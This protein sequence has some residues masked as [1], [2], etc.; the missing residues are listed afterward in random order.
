MLLLGIIAVSLFAVYCWPSLQ[1]VALV[2]LCVFLLLKLVSHFMV[3]PPWMAQSSGELTT[4]ITGRAKIW[5]DGKITNPNQ[6]YGLVYTDLRITCPTDKY[7]LS[8]WYVRHADNKQQQDDISISSSSSSSSS[9]KQ[10]VQKQKVAGKTCVVLVHG[11]GRDKRAF[12]RHMPVFQK[13]GYSTLAFD[14]REHGLSHKEG[15]G[16]GWTVREAQDCAV[17]SKYVRDTLGYENVVLCGTSQGA[18][19]SIV[20]AATLDKSVDAVIAENP[21]LSRDLLVEEILGLYLGSVWK[22]GVLLHLKKMMSK[23]GVMLVNS[24]LQV[25]AI[26]HPNAIDVIAKLAPRPVLL[27]HGTKDSLIGHHH[28]EL[29]HAAAGEPKALW[30]L[31]GAQHTALWDHDSETWEKTVLEFL[32]KH[33]L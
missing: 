13:A 5:Y 14:C 18:A 9:V 15:K 23:I 30:I 11:G 25:D 4:K 20:A 10:R 17:V 3:N 21:F 26:K 22:L 28:S 2:L 1:A 29:L 19:A 6:D 33:G 27:M 16:I 12:M 31:E 7:H 32:D 8:A 24:S